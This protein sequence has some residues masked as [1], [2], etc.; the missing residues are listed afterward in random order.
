MS[1]TYRKPSLNTGHRTEFEAAFWELPTYLRYWPNSC[2]RL[3]PKSEKFVDRNS[4]EFKRAMAKAVRDHGNRGYL[5]P[6]IKQAT[7]RRL[8]SYYR[9]ELQDFY[10][11][12]II[13]VNYR[14]LV[15]TYAYC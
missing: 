1:R 4:K 5:Q 12:E 14:K 2:Y 9:K 6:A 11:K 7:S 10:D 15:Y 8:R 13:H 3:I